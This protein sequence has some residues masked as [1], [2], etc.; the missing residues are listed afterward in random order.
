MY[1]SIRTCLTNYTC[2]SFPSDR[3]IRQSCNSYHKFTYVKYILC[4]N[5]QTVTYIIIIY[6]NFI[7]V[8]IVTKFIREI[9]MITSLFFFFVVRFYYSLFLCACILQTGLSKTEIWRKK[10]IRRPRIEMW[11]AFV[12][13]HHTLGCSNIGTRIAAVE[14]KA[15]IKRCSWI[16]IGRT[17]SA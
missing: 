3:N 6:D 5:F 16:L 2:P 7:Y 13:T 11:H 9:N 12:H 1:A 10:Q 17:R 8:H 14:S 15:S 4:R